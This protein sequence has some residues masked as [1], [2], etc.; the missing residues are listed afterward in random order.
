MLHKSNQKMLNVQRVVGQDACMNP[1][2]PD[3]TVHAEDCVESNEDQ[4]NIKLHVTDTVMS[5]ESKQHRITKPH[6][7]HKAPK[8]MKK[9]TS[10]DAKHVGASDISE[11][12]LFVSKTL[13][14]AKPVSLVPHRR[15]VLTNILHSWQWEFGEVDHDSVCRAADVMCVENAG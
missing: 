15:E 7:S 14:N 11:C 8:F 4:S 9:T 10:S 2:T 6:K 12:L 3:D 13:E 1:E 5:K